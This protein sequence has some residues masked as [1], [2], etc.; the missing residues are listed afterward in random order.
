[1][2]MPEVPAIFDGYTERVRS[3]LPATRKLTYHLDERT[4][5]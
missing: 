4:K 2:K 1:M 5:P 3:K